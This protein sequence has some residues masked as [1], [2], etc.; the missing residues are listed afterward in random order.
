MTQDSTPLILICVT[1]ML[2]LVISVVVSGRL[3]NGLQDAVRRMRTR[4]E[5]SKPQNSNKG[6]PG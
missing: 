3:F 6:N 2:L 1:G 5:E 4:S